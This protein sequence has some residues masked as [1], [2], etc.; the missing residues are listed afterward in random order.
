MGSMQT[1]GKENPAAEAIFKCP[2]TNVLLIEDNQIA[3]RLIQI[4]TSAAGLTPSS[5]LDGEQALE[6]AKKHSFD[7]IITDIGLPGISGYEFTHELRHWEQQNHRT[8]VPI[9]GLTAYDLPEAK[10][11]G[12]ESGM[13]HVLCK[14]IHLETIRELVQHFIPFAS[15][16]THKS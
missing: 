10:I 3:L 8:P 12:L 11:K 1:Q 14:P 13:N 7:I 5:A 2:I 16:N 15:H 6:M 4:L 9:V